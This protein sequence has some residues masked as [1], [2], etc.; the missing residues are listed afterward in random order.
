MN[1]D[2]IPIETFVTEGMIDA[3]WCIEWLECVVGIIGR[4]FQPDTEPSDYRPELHPLD[5]EA[6]VDGLA[7]CFALLGSDVYNVVDKA[8]LAADFKASVRYDLGPTLADLIGGD[9]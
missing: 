7:A 5:V 8:N 4:D 2:I 6:L 9:E 1:R 3:R